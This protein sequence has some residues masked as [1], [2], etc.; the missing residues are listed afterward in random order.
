VDASRRR[1]KFIAMLHR[2]LLSPLEGERKTGARRLKKGEKGFFGHSMK[3][4]F[5]AVR[6]SFVRCWR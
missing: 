4:W 6:S 1:G 3:L 2:G 5:A